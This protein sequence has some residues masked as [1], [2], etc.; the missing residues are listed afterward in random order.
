MAG[1]QATPTT[2][3]REFGLCRDTAR[4]ELRREGPARYTR[5]KPPELTPA[6]LAHAERRPC[7]LRDVT[8]LPCPRRMDPSLGALTACAALPRLSRGR[9]LPELRDDV[10]AAVLDQPA[11][12]SI[13]L[14]GIQVRDE[15]VDAFEPTPGGET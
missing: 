4:R 15:C 12:H 11:T 2:V 14:L 1:C 7:R 9:H 10:P 6:Q 3:A 5:A 8:C 13:A